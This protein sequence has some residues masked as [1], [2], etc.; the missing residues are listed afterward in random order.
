[1]GSFRSED[2]LRLAEAIRRRMIQGRPYVHLGV[3]LAREIV[4]VL[5]QA[6]ERMPYEKED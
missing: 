1:M 5:E 2:Y 4:A 3:V 6:A